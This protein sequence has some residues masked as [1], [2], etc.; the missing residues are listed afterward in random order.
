MVCHSVLQSKCRLKL[1]FMKAISH[2]FSLR[3]K[4]TTRLGP[5]GCRAAT[6][7]HQDHATEIA[8]PESTDSSGD[9]SGES[10]HRWAPRNKCANRLSPWRHRLDM[11]LSSELT[12]RAHARQERRNRD[13][14]NTAEARDVRALIQRTAAV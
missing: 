2:L 10:I 9:S 11:Q 13:A 12:K 14:G 4:S 5:L 6:R 1:Y 3:L 8:G 7:I